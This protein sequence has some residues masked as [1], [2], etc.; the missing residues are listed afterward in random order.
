VLSSYTD[1]WQLILGVIFLV[2]V[3]ALRDGIVGRFRRLMVR[4][5]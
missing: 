2:F 4:R 3:F 5:T 1:R